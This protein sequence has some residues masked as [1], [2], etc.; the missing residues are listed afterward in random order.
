[1]RLSWKLRDIG[2]DPSQLSWS[3]KAVFHFFH[4]PSAVS[5]RL[6]SKNQAFICVFFW[7]DC[8]RIIGSGLKKPHTFDRNAAIEPKFWKEEIEEK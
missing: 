8:Y 4:C 7:K 5:V 1:M 2:L 3:F 6:L